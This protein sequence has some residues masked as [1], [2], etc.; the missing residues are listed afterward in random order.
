MKKL[1]CILLIDDD[2]ISNY[3]AEYIII[4]EGL[5]EKT[6]IACNGEDGLQKLLD[7]QKESQASPE[8]ILLDIKMPVM[9]GFE[10]LRKYNQLDLE[11]KPRVV[12][13]TSSDNPQD[14][15]HAEEYNIAAYLN[16]PLSAGVLREII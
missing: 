9:D 12:L 1:R 16:K 10:F 5:A 13:L 6:V 14:K 2:E 15:S 3:L 4:E 11:Y 8:L 7:L